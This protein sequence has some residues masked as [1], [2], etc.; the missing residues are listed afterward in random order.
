MNYQEARE[1]L[2]HI[3]KRGSLLGLET[4]RLLLEELGNPQDRL[5]FIHVAGTN[6]KGSVM[7]YL[8]TILIR[9]GYRVGRYLSPVLFC[10]EEKIQVNGTY[11]SKEEVAED[12]DRIK[13]AVE[14]LEAKELPLPTIFEVETAMSFLHFLRHNCDLVLLETGMGGREDATNLV[15]TT[16]LEILT[17]ISMDHMEFLGDTLGKIAWNKAGII[18]P[19]TI[20][21]CDEQKEEARL[22]IEETCRDMKASLQSVSTGRIHHVSYGLL[23]QS[24]DYETQNGEGYENLIIHLSGTCQIQNA[25]T[26]VEAVSALK[27]LGYEISEAVV[28]EGL[29]DTRWEG[30]F[31]LL[32]SEPM[33]VMD[34]AHNPDAAQKLMDA[35]HQYFEGRKIFYI[36]GV[37]SDKEYARIIDITAGRAE[38]IYTIATK[39]NPRA[40]PADELAEAVARVNPHVEAV[41]DARLA[42]ERA[43]QEADREDV[44]LI[45]GSLSH[46]WE[47]KEFFARA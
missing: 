13:E 27:K 2:E 24:F 15:T 4:M 35:V 9:A 19:G 12:V 31:S 32:R 21:V 1:Y 29:S 40:M 28:R 20:C 6:G 46:L 26:A 23:E 3:S 22:V 44:I 36:F 7:S 25:A 37:F 8:E 45:F 11:I 16:V 17:S 5:K 10:Y 18:K 38:K 43:M 39:D 33:V 41:G 42:F 30:R 14:R 34:G 47:A